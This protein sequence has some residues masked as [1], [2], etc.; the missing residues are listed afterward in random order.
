MPGLRKIA[1]LGSVLASTAL[2]SGCGP[3]ALSRSLSPESGKVSPGSPVPPAVS[4]VVHVITEPQAGVSLWLQLMAQARTGIEIN[5][6]L[7]DDPAILAALRQ[8]GARGV[9]ITVL[10]APNP[11]HA[12]SWV[13]SEEAALR[14]LPDCAV[15]TAPARFGRSWA[16]DHAKYIVVNPGTSQVTALIGSPNFTKSAFDGSNLEAA[17]QVTG[18][19][20]QAAASVFHADWTRQPAGSGP[21]RALVLSPGSQP[22]LTT[23]LEQPGPIAIMAE[24]LGDDPSLWH[25]LAQDGARVRL[26]LAAPESATTRHAAHILQAAGVQI[27]TLS[28]PYVHAKVIITTQ[29]VFIGSENLSWVS[30]AHN[31]EMGLI[32]SGA[33]RTSMIPWFNHYWHQAGTRSPASVSSPASHRPWLAAGLSMARVRAL[34][35]SP[36]TTYPT[37][38]HGQAE[39]AWAYA[40]H[41]VYFVQG[42]LSAVT[43]HP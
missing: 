36:H 28:H 14:A 7:I 39:I 22:V 26:L 20:A 4:S 29:N 8:A 5:A 35:G 31:R 23:L 10:L 25:T 15:K 38:Y 33:A 24:E 40:H 42:R 12:T 6:Y 30:L 34:W 18:A 1:M 13:P 43:D 32:V 9:P 16:Y 3:E 41:T 27:R 17:V 19:A 2:L 21:R 11:Y 37:T